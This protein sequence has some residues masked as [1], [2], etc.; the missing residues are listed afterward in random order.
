MT[1]LFTLNQS[2]GNNY[3][4]HVTWLFT[5]NWSTGN[6]YR[7]AFFL[8][9]RLSIPQSSRKLLTS[10]V[11]CLW[12]VLQLRLSSRI[13]LAFYRRNRPLLYKQNCIDVVIYTNKRMS[14][15]NVIECGRFLSQSRCLPL[16]K[17]I[18]QFEMI[19]EMMA[20]DI[21]LSLSRSR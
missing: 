14:A 11:G 2:T 3:T 7:H 4:I 6:N 13:N 12:E 1:W 5:L 18:V 19:H 9:A 8:G 15:Q 10:N 16:F 17:S 21:G 20:I